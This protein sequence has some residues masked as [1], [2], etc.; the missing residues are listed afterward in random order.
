MSGAVLVGIMGCGRAAER[1]HVPAILRMRDARLTACCD[2]LPERRQLISRAAPGCRAFVSPEEMLAAR[3]VDAVIVASSPETHAALAAIALRA[4]LPV[5]VEK[6][7]AATPAEAVAL[8]ELEAQHPAAGDGRVQSSVVGARSGPSP[9]GGPARRRT[10]DRGDV[11]RQRSQRL[12]RARPGGDP[13]EDLAVHHLHLLPYLLDRVIATVS[14]QRPAP[15]EVELALT[16]HGGSA[17]RCVAAF[18]PKSAELL[19][20]ESGGRHF[21]IKTSSGR[22][23]PADGPVRDA[24]DLAG[25][26]SRRILGRRGGLTRSYERQLRAFLDCVQADRGGLAV[27]PGTADGIAALLAVQAAR[28]SLAQL[29]AEICVPHLATS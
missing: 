26:V 19:K 28:D 10:G 7:L 11:D 27:S 22:T 25:A 21:L 24:L 18:G 1:L 6:P 29:G 16:F 8:L 12:G 5:L 17:A 2:P 15:G 23:R 14:A 4:G 20:V 13:L 9:C 3:G